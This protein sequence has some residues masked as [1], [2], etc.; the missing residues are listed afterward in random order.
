V[1]GFIEHLPPGVPSPILPGDRLRLIARGNCS[2]VH[3]IETRTTP[4]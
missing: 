3:V 1:D 2:D 4:R